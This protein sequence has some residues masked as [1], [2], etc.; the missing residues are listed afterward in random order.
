MEYASYKYYVEE[1]GGSLSEDEFNRFSRKA[2]AYIDTIT[3]NR[4]AKAMSG[5]FA[6]RIKEACCGVVDVMM[7]N[8]N[9]GGIASE[10]ND[11]ISVTYVSSGDEKKSPEQRLYSE[12]LIYLGTTGLMYRG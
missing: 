12:A 8:E 9:G 6:G 10:T 1:Y 11:G 3:F 5:M 2:S 7:K 4:A